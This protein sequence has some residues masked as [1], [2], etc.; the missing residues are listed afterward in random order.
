MK[1]FDA[2]R[3]SE[4]SCA[5]Q[6]KVGAFQKKFQESFGVG[7]RVYVKTSNRPASEDRTLAST[8]EDGF[9]G[10]GNEVAIRWNMRVGDVEAE[11]KDKMGVKIQVLSFD[12]SLANN[13]L[14]LGDLRR[15]TK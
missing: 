5:P 6:T 15:Q 1:L 7:V 13:D 2:F 10:E 8:K 11:F 14:T 9:K 4:L 3:K 12:G